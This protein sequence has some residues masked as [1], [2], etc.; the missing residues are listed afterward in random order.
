MKLRDHE[1]IIGKLSDVE[2]NKDEHILHFSHTSKVHVPSSIFNKEFLETYIGEDIGL[3]N[4]DGTYHI[5][6]L[7]DEN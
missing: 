5:R 4:M 6:F 3:L 2:S 7:E 1:E